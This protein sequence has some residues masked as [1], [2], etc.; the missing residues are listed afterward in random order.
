LEGVPAHLD[1][2]E[3]RAALAQVDGVKEV[4]DLHLWSVTQGQEAMSSHLVVK[5]G[6]DVRAVL[7]S[8]RS[9]LIERFGLAH[10]TLQLEPED[11]K[12]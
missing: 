3:I 11:T 4:H 1:L 6:H 12:S 2:E 9:M 5:S 7:S 10:V 8:G